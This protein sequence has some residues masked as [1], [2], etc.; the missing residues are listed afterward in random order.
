MSSTPRGMA[1]A[2]RPRG[3]AGLSYG[4]PGLPLTFVALPLYVTLPHHYANSLGMPLAA[5]GALMLLVRA[6]DGLS[7]P[8][9]GG[10]ADRLLQQPGR[11]MVSVL[12]LTAVVLWLGF[13]AIFLPPGSVAASPG[14]LWWWAAATLLLTCVAYSLL[15]V[16]H[17]AWA[18]RLGGGDAGQSGWA[19]WREG[20]SLVGVVMASVLPSL[21]GVSALVVVFAAVL[22]LG[23]VAWAMA[24]RPRSLG[25][26][27]LRLGQLATPAASVAARA[28]RLRSLP[29]R[30]VGFRR[31]YLVFIV[32]GV[33][34]AIPAT[35]L[36][37][38]VDDRLQAPGAEGGLLALYFCAGAVSLPLWVRL[39][40]RWGLARCWALGMALAIVAFAGAALLQ[41]GDLLWFAAIC[42]ASGLALGA[43]LALPAAL[44]AR[45][46]GEAGHGE[47]DEGAYFGWWNAAAKLNL[48]L[49]AGLGLPLLQWFGYSP[50]SDDPIA[51]AWLAWM[52][53][54]LP[55]LLKLM[56][57]A[58]LWRWRHAWPVT[59]ATTTAPSVSL[60]PDPVARS[61]P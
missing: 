55:C 6:T 51:L 49:A 2:A 61:L 38:Y 4:L 3:W 41:A 24:P 60:S 26:Q 15:V 30:S 7:D 45:V 56:A 43:D 25:V 1:G 42:L 37:F 50:G 19:A 16:V 44:L 29:W 9:I 14:T 39:V 11:R 12:L 54:G 48:A 18:V 46:I 28:R 47:S 20:A 57:L 27:R 35:L 8:W 40:P 10:L 33:A 34:A 58:L 36:L 5:L 32:N 13:A 59:H 21:F 53:G 17:Q 52:Y 22:L 31:L 23:A